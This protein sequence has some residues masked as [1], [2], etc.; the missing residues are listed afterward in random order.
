MTLSTLFKKILRLRTKLDDDQMKAGT[1]FMLCLSDT[2][3]TLQSGGYTENL[4]PG[5]DHLTCQSGKYTLYPKDFFIDEIFRFE[6]SSDPSDQSILYAITCDKHNIRGL[7]IESYGVYHDELSAAMLERIKYC[8]AQCK[9][10]SAYKDKVRSYA[11]E[12]TLK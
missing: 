9:S 3:T 10:P 5:Y 7:Y 2:I 8:R 12:T 4:V 6:N 11:P 1:G